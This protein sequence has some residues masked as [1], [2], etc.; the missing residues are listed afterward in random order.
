MFRQFIGN[1]RDKN[2]IVHTQDNLHEGIMFIDEKGMIDEWNSAMEKIVGFDGEKAI[3]RFAWD[4]Q[5][6]LVPEDKKNET[7]YTNIKSRLQ[8]FLKNGEAE[9]I[10]KTRE[11]TIPQKN[12]EYKTIEEF[13]FPIRTEKGFMMGIIFRDITERKYAEEA[14]RESEEK[15]RILAETTQ[16]IILLHDM[17][18]NVVYVNKAGLDFKGFEN[19]MKVG[20]NIIDFTP[21][22]Q[23]EETQIRKEKRESGDDNT[24][25]YELNFPDSRGNMYPVEIHSTPVFRKGKVNEILI[26]ARDITERKNAENELKLKNEEYLSINEELRESLQQIQRMNIELEKAKRKA[27]ES[28]RLKTAFLCNMSHEIRT[29]MNGII[30][31]S[32]LLNEPGTSED[33]RSYFSEIIQN[34]GQQLL[35]IVNNILDISKIETGQMEVQFKNVSLNKIISDT[36]TF[37]KPQAQK[38]GISLYPKK[39]L[40]DESGFVKTDEMKLQQVLNNLINNSL[41]FTS[42]GYIEFGYQLRDNVVE[43]FVRDT[44]IGIRKDLHEAIFERFQQ[45]ETGLN[46]QHGGAGLGLSICKSLVGLLGGRIWFESEE[47]KGTNF[48]F[49]IPFTQEVSKSIVSKP[50]TEKSSISPVIM[51]VEDEEV[52]FLYMEEVLKVMNLEILHAKDGEEAVEI[53]RQ[54]AD[55]KIILMDI[56]LPVMN[57]YEATKEIKKIRS[58]VPIVAQTAYAMTTDKEEA[59]STGCDDYISKPI[60]KAELIDIV[61]KY[62]V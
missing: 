3:G 18:G 29:P 53:C 37:F 43:F 39:S 27:E 62:L 52:N 38:N 45:G 41:K 35:T 42:A 49:S 24:F 30:G 25:R 58:D 19:R 21:N 46:R 10:D 48:Y 60:K 20:V 56:K 44:G 14:L 33:D 61:K 4:I 40:P 15:Y 51:V 8:R 22:Q 36:Y 13:A 47:N 28:D 5:Y 11:I 57:G 31:F 32:E 9:W 2:N 26:V 6:E 34:S 1:N 7:L 50:S 23:L 54:R 12:G 59:L 16:D 17:E 55:I